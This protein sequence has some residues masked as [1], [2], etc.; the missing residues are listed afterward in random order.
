MA[1]ELIGVTAKVSRELHT[2][3]GIVASENRR[4]LAET[5]R[6]ALEEYVHR[7]KRK[8]AA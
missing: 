2:D 7:N 3:L 5:I 4:S 8:E 1:E 6:I